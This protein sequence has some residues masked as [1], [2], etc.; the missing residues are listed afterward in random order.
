VKFAHP[1]EGNFAIF[2][3]LQEVKVMP[4]NNVLNEMARDF[5]HFISPDVE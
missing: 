5:F 2:W 4:T 1:M 3:K